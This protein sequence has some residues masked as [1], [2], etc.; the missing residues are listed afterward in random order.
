MKE[1][2]KKAKGLGSAIEKVTEATGIKKVVEAGA[3]ALNKDCGCGK[4]R[5]FLDNPDLM[6]NKVFFKDNNKNK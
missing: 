5:D 4:R 6:V 3:K 2:S 1:Q